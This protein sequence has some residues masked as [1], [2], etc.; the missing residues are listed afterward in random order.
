[1]TDTAPQIP[2]YRVLPWMGSDH[3]FIAPENVPAGSVIETDAPPGPHLEPLNEAAELRMEEWYSEAFPAKDEKGKL[4]RGQF[5]YPHAKY[6]VVAYSPGDQQTARIISGPPKDEGTTNPLSLAEIAAR[7]PTVNT[8]QRPG[9]A[10][11]S[12]R[13]RAEEGAAIDL[14]PTPSGIT[15]S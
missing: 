7:A 15:V 12:R 4:L 1:M 10:A 6:R 13:V 9:P 5:E 8:D 11:N 14:A 2:I 3:T